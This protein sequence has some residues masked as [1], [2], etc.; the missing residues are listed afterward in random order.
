MGMANRNMCEHNSPM[1]LLIFMGP[2]F[3]ADSG[4]TTS[5]MVR[6]TRIPNTMARDEYP[7]CE[8]GKS[9]ARRV[10]DRRRAQADEEVKKGAK[11][12]TSQTHLEGPLAE[13]ATGDELEDAHGRRA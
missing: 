10:I 4:T 6:K 8:E 9:Q 5:R 12:R 1:M 7:A 11:G 13:Y 3:T 2:D